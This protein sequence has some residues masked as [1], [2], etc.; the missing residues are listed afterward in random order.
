MQMYIFVAIILSFA[1]SVVLYVLTVESDFE[2][3]LLALV[4]WL[5]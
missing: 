3:H 2:S 5:D 4:L 1:F